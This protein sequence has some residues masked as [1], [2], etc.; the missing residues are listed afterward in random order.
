MVVIVAT[1]L[2]RLVAN[3]QGA[4]FLIYLSIG[5]IDLREDLVLLAE[6]GLTL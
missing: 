1:L 5:L 3:Q 2:A 4:S 6:K